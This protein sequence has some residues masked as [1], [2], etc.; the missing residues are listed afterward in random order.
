MRV[1]EV[2]EELVFYI[3]ILYT[4]DLDDFNILPRY[5]IKKYH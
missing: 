1:L 5:Y 4:Y 2:R 3:I